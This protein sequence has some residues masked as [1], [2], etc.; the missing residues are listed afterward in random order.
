V[1]AGRHIPGHINP[2]T[3]EIEFVQAMDPEI[4]DL[5]DDLA[6]VVLQHG[7]EVVVVPAER[8]PAQTGVAAIYRY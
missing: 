2:A 8:M 6:E 7:G 4:D 3:G 5:L 1:E